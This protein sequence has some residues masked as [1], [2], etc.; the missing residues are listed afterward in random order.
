MGASMSS[1]SVDDLEITRFVT[2]FVEKI[3]YTGQISFDF[4]RSKE[5]LY[6]IECNPRAT[7]GIHLF[8]CSPGLAKA[9]LEKSY[10]MG[11][12][13][14][15]YHEPITMLLYGFK[16]KEIF[17]KRFL[18]N[19]LM[20]KNVLFQAFDFGPLFFLPL[21]LFEIFKLTLTRGKKLNEVLSEDLEYNGEDS[22]VLL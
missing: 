7:S 17:K 15:I 10:L 20:G 18:K 9:F 6:V 21:V 19:I 12:I 3:N 2:E 8:E 14:K 1:L 4:I 16:Q 13:G 11:T 5:R 22:C